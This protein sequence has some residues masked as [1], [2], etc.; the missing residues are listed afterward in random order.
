M[1]L[2]EAT[3]E[4]EVGVCGSEEKRHYTGMGAKELA[5][6]LESEHGSEAQRVKSI[7]REGSRG[8][9]RGGNGDGGSEEKD[10]TLEWGRSRQA[11]WSHNTDRRHKSEEYKK[12][13]E[14]RCGD[15]KRGE[16][17]EEQSRREEQS[18]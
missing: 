11:R 18:C 3:E 16:H 10:I 9:G 4:A 6:S 15:V 17:R 8:G 7:E 2:Q 5:S 12:G 1:G 13:G 14:Q